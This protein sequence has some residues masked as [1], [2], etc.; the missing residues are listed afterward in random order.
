MIIFV[1]LL[2]WPRTLWYQL[3]FLD[4]YILSEGT[5]RNQL[6]WNINKVEILITNLGRHA[7]TYIH[8]PQSRRRNRLVPN[9]VFQKNKYFSEKK[10]THLLNL[11]FLTSQGIDSLMISQILLQKWRGREVQLRKEGRGKVSTRKSSD[12]EEGQ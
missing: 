12:S 3:K 1:F 2:I 11:F 10:K 4:N 9:N 8:F 5:R 6:S 7:P